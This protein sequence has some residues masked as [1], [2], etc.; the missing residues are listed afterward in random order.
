MADYYTLLTNAGIAYETACKAAGTPIKLTQI[1]V[2]DG[3]EG[4][5][6]NPAATAT[7]LKREVWRGPLNAL[8]Q[9][10]KN[11]SWLLAEVT[12]PPDVGG[13]YVREAGLWTDTG[14]LYAIVKYPESFKPVLANSG[15]G[16][17]FYIRSIFETSNASL[18]TLLIDDTVVKATRAWVMSYL[19]EEL[20]KLDG[21]QSVRVAATANV[22][23]N[24]AQQ[25]DGVA[26]IAGDRVLLPNQTLAKDNGLWIV[27]NGNWIRANDANV[28]A[29]VTPGLT[30]MVEEG[31]LNGDSLWHL[32]TNAPITLGTTALTFKMLAGR[33]GIAAGTYK[34]LSVDEYGRATAGSN[35]DTLAGFGIK[36]SYTKAEVEA[37]IAKASALPVGS[38]VAF[39]VDTPPPGFLE[40]DNSVKSSAT[41]PDLSAYLGGKFN[42][43]DEGVGNFRLPEARGEFLRGWDHGRGIDGGRAIGSSQTDTM[44]NIYGTFDGYLDISTVSGAF[45]MGNMSR[46][47]APLNQK[48]AYHS[49]VLDASKVA[50]TSAE[51]RPRN[52]AVMWCIKAWNAPINQGNIDVAA[53]V[54]E[55]SRLGS[56]VPVGAVMAFPT[57][58]V[59]PGF[60][61]LNGSVQSTSTYPDLAAYLGT[62]Y[63]KGDEGAGN[64]RLPE[65]RG[66]FLR[67]WDHGRGVDPGRAIGSWAP[68]E[69]KSHVHQ[70]DAPA[71]P[72]GFGQDKV[73]RGNRSD[74][75]GT[76]QTTATGG[77]ETRPR[78]IAVMWCIKA[79]NAPINQ[80]NIDVAALA[81]E[82]AQL[83]SS[84]PVGAVLSFPTGVVPA[85]YLELD[86]SVQSIATYPDLAG[87]LGTKFNKGDEGAGNF[88]LPESRGEFLRGWDHGRGVDAGRTIGSWQK[89]TLV[90]HDAVTSTAQAIQ[91]AAS[92]WKLN[93]DNSGKSHPVLGG[94][95]ASAA[96][97]P[98]A[99]FSSGEI[100]SPVS[101]NQ[102][103]LFTDGHL[104]GTRPRNLAVMWC[105]KAWNAPVNQGSI[106]VAA[107]APLAQQATEIKQGTAKLATQA[108]TDAGADDTTIVT[109]KKL[110]WG[111]QILKE[112]NG[113]IIFPSWLGG[114]I[115]QWG[116]VSGNGG[117]DIATA[118]PI[119]FPNG[120]Y[121]LNATL[122]YTPGAAVNGYVDVGVSNLTSFYG[123]HTFPGVTVFHWVAVGS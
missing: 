49:V 67:G 46:S 90:A 54:K 74:S 8:F 63:N 94:D 34:S 69:L 83:K 123:K 100:T 1:S 25:I 87:Y 26:V 3:G 111:F 4:G 86:G 17:E 9:D 118:F 60:L 6:Y 71:N 11:P 91:A 28:S 96:D 61:E 16:K 95:V 42:K 30:V 105:I 22:V 7:A 50:R 120:M 12:I 84:V 44:Q 106:D 18:V 23:L 89:A 38:I 5:V 53:L 93:P 121:S 72:S 20:G 40:L 70:V 109:P 39:P 104:V 43:G 41:Y 36:D 115:I 116:R 58:I 2:G 103:A 92:S 24:G 52:I 51:T 32:T 48:D 99:F 81:N 66:E 112:I 77:S 64:F 97:Y 59:P 37:L 19:A 76:P 27:A 75:N 65:S 47:S 68:D 102:A 15:S 114:L 98:S 62:T 82:V 108:L 101:L 21:K 13:W 110:R 55:V 33:T 119:A 117:T 35:P 88:R 10:E 57:G 107:L 79:W 113:Y 14:I 78:S 56:A 122:N 80:G 73:A 31:T 85:G 29:K 45:T